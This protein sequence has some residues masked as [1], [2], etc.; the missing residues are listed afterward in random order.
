MTST[1]LSLARSG[2]MNDLSKAEQFAHRMTRI[3]R[4]AL[5]CE[6]YGTVSVVVDQ[7]HA[8]N[9][10]RKVVP[11]ATSADLYHALAILQDRLDAAVP[12]W[13]RR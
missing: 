10:L 11:T 3:P 6:V 9:I 12:D 4:K 7:G 2:A 1:F 13:E 8:K 5:R